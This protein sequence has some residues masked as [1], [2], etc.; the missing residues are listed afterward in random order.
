MVYKVLA[1]YK[2]TVSKSVNRLATVTRSRSHNEWAFTFRQSFAIVAAR[3][4]RNNLLERPLIA[5][6]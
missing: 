1:I 6:E 3:K 4:L 2:A 5:L